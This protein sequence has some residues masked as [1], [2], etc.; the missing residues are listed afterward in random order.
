MH[1]SYNGGR[2]KNMPF[3]LDPP[4]NVLLLHWGEHKNILVRFSFK[5]NAPNS[6]CYLSRDLLQKR[7]M[8]YAKVIKKRE[9]KNGE[10]FEISR[11]IRER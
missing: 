4:K 7:G 6:Y 5:I 8:G 11:K 10:V 1:Y 2:R 9:L 3:H